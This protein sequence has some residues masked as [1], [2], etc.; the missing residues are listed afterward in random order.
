M[1]S[2]LYIDETLILAQPQIMTNMEIVCNT[3]DTCIRAAYSLCMDNVTAKAAVGNTGRFLHL[4][5]GVELSMRNTRVGGFN[6]GEYGQRYGEAIYGAAVHAGDGGNDITMDSCTVSNNT[7]KYGAA[8]NLA[9]GT[10]VMLHSRME[11]NYA[12]PDDGGAGGAAIL[13]L[14]TVT[15]STSTFAYNR[16]GNAGGALFIDECNV[17]ITASTFLSNAAT[18]GGAISSWRNHNATLTGNT[19]RGNTAP[20]GNDVYCDTNIVTPTPINISPAL[21]SG[22]IYNHDSNCQINNPT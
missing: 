17:T 22:N 15:I 1:S 12:A 3:S 2:N 10:L 11:H 18:Q 7:G 9:E 16:A 21:P 13:I 6:A 5:R 8:L 4:T 14:S 20:Q 19:L